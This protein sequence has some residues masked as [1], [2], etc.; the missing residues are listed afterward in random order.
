MIMIANNGN[1][2]RFL[3][4]QTKNRAARQIHEVIHLKS[5]NYNFIIYF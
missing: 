3:D 1:G 2:K 5:Y 4:S